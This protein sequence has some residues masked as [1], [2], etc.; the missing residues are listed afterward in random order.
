MTEVDVS[1]DLSYVTIS[2][3]A[4]QKP[5]LAIEFLHSKQRE[6]QRKL[7][8]L[9]THRTPKLRFTLD[10]TAERTSRLDQLLSGTD[11]HTPQGSSGV[12]Q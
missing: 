10:R 4:L 9:Q 12:S 5:E 3:S 1:P 7:A 6:L 8:G 11:L 2:I